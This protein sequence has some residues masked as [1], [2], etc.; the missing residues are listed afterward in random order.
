MARFGMTFFEPRPPAPANEMPPWRPPL[1]LGV[2]FG[3]GRTA[4]RGG[5]GA[6]IF[7]IPKDAD[8]VP[9][10]PYVA[11]MGGGGGGHE[12]HMR[13]WVFPLPSDGPLDIFVQVGD[14]PEGHATID[15]AAVRAAATRAEVIWS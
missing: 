4:G 9:T 15:G 10:V 14:L 13:V 7:D 6:N 12:F 5:A 8:G 1:W 11:G 2:R 3:D